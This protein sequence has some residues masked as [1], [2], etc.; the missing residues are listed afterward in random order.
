MVRGMHYSYITQKANSCTSVF[1]VVYRP[2]KWV[3][4]DPKIVLALVAFWALM[5]VAWALLER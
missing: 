1:V 4:R 2:E 5:L 3:F